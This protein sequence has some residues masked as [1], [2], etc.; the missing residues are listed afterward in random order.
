MRRTVRELLD[1]AGPYVLAILVHAAAAG[2]LVLSVQWPGVKRSPIEIAD[3]VQATVVDEKRVQK[4][5][6]RIRDHETAKRREEEE[7]AEVAR[8]QR[9]HEERLREEAEAA[10]LAEE[11]LRQKAER[12]RLAEEERRK[13]A[14]TDRLA[15]ER[16]RV[17][18]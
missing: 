17:E 6:E 16:R 7:R 10:R 1:Q 12:E 4:E 3:A 2:V 11:E 14:E 15:E 13:E 9:E 18:A 8:E 5:L